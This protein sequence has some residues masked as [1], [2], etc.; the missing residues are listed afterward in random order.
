VKAGVKTPWTYTLILT[1]LLLFRIIW[2]IGK[3]R[4]K[5]APARIPVRAVPS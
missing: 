3:S 1:A 4:S 5:P 2:R